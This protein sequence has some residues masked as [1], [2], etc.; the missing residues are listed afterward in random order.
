MVDG[1]VRTTVG[2]Q[3]IHLKTASPCADEQGIF[4]GETMYYILVKYF[5]FGGTY[6]AEKDGPLEDEWGVR[7][8][9][10]KEEASDFLRL[11]KNLWNFQGSKWT[12]DSSQGLY[13]CAHGEYEPPV[14]WVRKVRGS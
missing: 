2:L 8:F 5:Y 1:D 6:G 10:S 3:T 9:S 13:R 11:E 14:Y 4:N 12:W 7:Y